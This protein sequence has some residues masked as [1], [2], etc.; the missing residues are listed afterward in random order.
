MT[1]SFAEAPLSPRA[2]SPGNLVS[3]S[4]RYS[5]PPRTAT[6]PP[7]LTSVML[8][9]RPRPWARTLPVMCTSPAIS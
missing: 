6:Q 2:H 3:F 9:F 8:A 1:R 5:S 7:L 4:M